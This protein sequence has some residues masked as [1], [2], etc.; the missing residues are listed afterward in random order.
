MATNFIINIFAFSALT[1]MWLGFGASILF[2]PAFLDTVWQAFRGLPL[3]AQGA[4]TLFTLPVTL[5][6]WVWETSWP[7]LIRL[8]LVIGLGYVTIYTFFPRHA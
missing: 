6:L 7:L 4:I 8:I 2:N 5:G 1:L 3:L